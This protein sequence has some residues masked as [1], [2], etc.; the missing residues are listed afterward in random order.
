MA[1]TKRVKIVDI[2]VNVLDA[3]DAI[4]KYGEAIAACK[5]RLKDL[6][7]ANDDGKMSSKT[8]HQEVAFA[9]QEIKAYAT[10]QNVLTKQIQNQVQI[11]KAQQGSLRA[12]RAELKNATMQ[13]EALGKAERESL[14][15]QQ[16]KQHI[17]SLKSEI[18]SA[19][20]ETQTFYK[21]VG[22]TSAAQ[23]G[24]GGLTSKIKGMVSQMALLATGGGIAAF[25]RDSIELG[26]QFYDQMASVKAVTQATSNEM[27]TLT[28]RARELGRSTKFHATDAAAAMETLA[29]GGFSTNETLTAINTTLQMAQANAVDLNTA[30]DIMIRTM[31]GFRMPITEEEMQRAADVLSQASRKSATNITEM[32]E[33]FKNAAPFAGALNIPIE[34]ISAALGVMADSGT[35]GADAGTAMRMALLGIAVPTS[36]AGKVFKEFGINLDQASLKS[37]GLAGVLNELNDSGIFKDKASMEKLSTIFGRRAVSNVINLIGNLDQYK[38][39]L[40]EIENSAGTTSQMFKQSLDAGSNAIYTLSSAFEDL[41][42]GVY[43]LNRDA[44]KNLSEML[45]QVLYA[46]T[47]NL[48]AISA[49]IR[50]VVLSVGTFKLGQVIIA[51]VA[52]AKAA[53]I[54]AAQQ[55][56]AALQANE[57]RIKQLKTETADLENTLNGQTAASAKM[58]ANERLV[59]EQQLAVKKKQIELEMAETAKL[60]DAAVA[61]NAKVASVSAASGW[62]SAMASAG[63]AIKGFTTT[64]KAAVSSI[65]IMLAISL[66]IEGIVK[67]YGFIT[68]LRK[69]STEVQDAHN[70][71]AQ[72]IKAQNEQ[73]SKSVSDSVAK[74]KSRLDLLHAA[75]TNNNRSL[76]ERQAAI[77]KLKAIVPGY[78][79]QLSKSG[80]LYNDNV[81]AIKNYVKNLENAARAEAAYSMYVENTKKI[82]QA[83]LVIEDATQKKKNIQDHRIARGQ[84]ADAKVS[85][86]TTMSGFGEGSSVNTEYYTTDLNGNKKAL[87]TEERKMLEHNNKMEAMFDSRI[88]KAKDAVT[89]LTAQQKTLQ[90]L[91][92]QGRKDNEKQTKTSG[93]PLDTDDGGE[94]ELTD[95]EKKKLAKE[96]AKKERAAATA[97]KKEQEALKLAHDA[98]LAILEDTISKRRQQ[99]EYQYNDEIGK[100]KTRLQHEKN[101]TA[102]A[103]DAINSAIKDKEAKRDIELSKLDDERIKEDV[104]RQQKLISARL[105]VAMKGTEDELKLK[106]EQVEQ[107]RILD[108]QGLNAE[109]SKAM[110]G[111]GQEVSAAKKEMDNA[112]GK[113]DTDTANGADADML[114]ADQ[115]YYNAKVA[116]YEEMQRRMTD[117]DQYYTEMRQSIETNA[118]Q[119]TMELDATFA[120]QQQDN[121]IQQMEQELAELQMQG[122]QQTELQKNLQAINLDVATQNDIE[123]AEKQKE[124]ADAK[125]E[126]QQQLQQQ[127]GESDD[128]YTQRLAA[129]SLTREQ[130][131]A[132]YQQAKQEQAAAAQNVN[133]L[134]TKN[135]EA[136]GKAFVNVQSSMISALD[137]LGETNTAFAKAAKIISLAQIAIDTGKALA[138]GVSSASSLPYPANLAAIATTVATVLANVATAISTV[139]SAKFAEGGKVIGPGTGTSDSISAQLSNGEYVMTAKA[140]RMYEPLL[141]AMNSVGSGVPMQVGTS[142]RDVQNANSISDS[143]VEAA[144]QIRP[145]VSVEEITDAQERIKIIQNL[146]VI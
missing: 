128:E 30:S 124:I 89:Q 15:G 119:Q 36:K 96:Q 105:A 75:I 108:E 47:N 72:A 117:L 73:I 53:T 129:N 56:T 127:E 98:E 50:D 130:A 70:A 1:D 94:T 139:K 60:H 66:V 138:A 123:Q 144:Q 49:A 140:T 87:N 82:M 97:A 126:W 107:Q 52:A 59:A 78:H 10:E 13:Y 146:D 101:L 42:I 46:I 131:D 136:K 18:A 16:L 86:N 67:L 34:Q 142:Y 109:R 48:P 103:R 111:A 84:A 32:G 27:Q 74:E 2:Q 58:S 116:A 11:E 29:R 102:T 113:L 9:R 76:G 63:L 122:E 133:N 22:D 90:K 145:I 61:A 92:E 33:A 69:A 25:S 100:L 91:A 44:L 115:E 106:K 54:T 3:I 24:V 20:K 79:A 4:G 88:E 51:Q 65:G 132:D 26:R 39:K 110:R 57:E 31:R 8:Y 83:Q 14:S 81:A 43:D 5:A 35:R 38:K 77:N 135:E 114:A 62:R 120:Q 104:A 64:V 37:K 99:I 71:M 68:K 17:T 40:D 55:T 12:M 134:E 143:F 19:S 23:A 28:D 7:K 21:N 45:I 80:Q 112:K 137:A 41:K 85:S 6:K 95:A 125:F 118:K 141:A 93:L 121:R